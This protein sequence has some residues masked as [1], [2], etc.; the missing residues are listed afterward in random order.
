[1]LL[2]LLMLPLHAGEQKKKWTKEYLAGEDGGGAYAF[3]AIPPA[4]RLRIATWADGKEARLVFSDAAIERKKRALVSH[5]YAFVFGKEGELESYF[6]LPHLLSSSNSHSPQTH[7]G[8]SSSRL[9]FYLF[10]SLPF[11]LFSIAP[12]D[13]LCGEKLNWGGGDVVAWANRQRV[14]STVRIFFSRALIIPCAGEGGFLK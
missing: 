9:F 7:N 11:S 4:R 14:S 10:L 1:M 13:R 6:P 12:R 2:L 3:A 8:S 5:V